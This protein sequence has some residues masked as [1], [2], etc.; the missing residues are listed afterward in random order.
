[1]TTTQQG[2]IP[3]NVSSDNGWVKKSCL[4][5]LASLLNERFGVALCLDFDGES[6]LISHGMAQGVIAIRMNPS[7]ANATLEGCGAW[8]ATEQGWCSALDGPIPS[9]GH[10]ALPADLI[11]S[12]ETGFVIGYD[13]LGL[14][15][16]MLSRREEVEHGLGDRYSRFPVELSHAYQHGYLHRPIVDE[17]LFIL[18]QVLQRQWPTLVLRPL[19]YSMRVSHDIDES[20]RYAFKSLR[21]LTRVVAIDV[22]RH[23][24]WLAPLRALY[25]RFK[26][27]RELIAGDPANTFDWLMSLSERYGLTS[28]FYFICGRTH[29]TM[30]ADYEPEAPAIR[31]LMRKIHSRGHEIGLHPSF[32]TFTRP[33][34][35]AA[36]A[37]RLRQI[38]AEEGIHQQAWG[39]RM[40]YLRWSHPLTMR[41]WDQAGMT[42]DST[43]GYADLPGFRCGTCYEYP[44]FD[45]V[46]RESLNLRIRP[47]VAMEVTVMSSKYMGLGCGPQAVAE[48]GNLIN[49]CRAVGGCFTLLWH[50]SN[51]SMAAERALYETVLEMGAVRAND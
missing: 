17:W 22:L 12:V 42:Y 34:V 2:S 8:N 25:V 18:R 11:K 51:L 36:E 43:L 13:I 1:M 26:A 46:A 32:D 35:I 3:N 10:T 48:F 5:W 33:E 45:P 41:A 28:A 9:P 19:H 38:C 30:D 27:R 50:N 6:L 29:P 44:A 20:S 47:L 23:R 40:H 16:W 37:E 21:G 39:G 7:F 15:Y 14:T 49:A 24:N 4:D 31:H